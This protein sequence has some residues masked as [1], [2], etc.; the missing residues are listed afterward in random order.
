MQSVMGCASIVAICAVVAIADLLIF[1]HTPL[2]SL[3]LA[4]KIVLL[5]LA[6]AAAAGLFVRWL[7]LRNW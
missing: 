7:L 3:W 2:L 1:E 4:T 6:G 5:L